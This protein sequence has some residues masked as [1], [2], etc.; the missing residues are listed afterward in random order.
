MFGIFVLFFALEKKNKKLIL[1]EFFSGWEILFS[2]EFIFLM[3]Y[4]YCFCYSS[5][6]LNKYEM[7]ICRSFY[8]NVVVMN[9]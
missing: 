9:R 4:I 8:S 7:E 6:V 1:K 3:N 5:N 2:H